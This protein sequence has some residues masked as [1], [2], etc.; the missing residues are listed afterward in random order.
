M[1]SALTLLLGH[2]RN[3]LMLED[4]FLTIERQE[5]DGWVVVARDSDWETR[6]GKISTFLPCKYFFYFI[7][8]HRT[9]VILG[10]SEVTVHWEI[11]LDV[12]DGTYR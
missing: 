2:L 12:E 7:E 5:E 9:N 8:W 11:P 1:T 3:N 10:E 6:L 4:T